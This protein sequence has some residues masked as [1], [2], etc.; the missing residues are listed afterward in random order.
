MAENAKGA[1]FKNTQKQGSQPDLTGSIEITREFWDEVKNHLT[2]EPLK[3]R[4]AAWNK[5]G[6]S[7]AFLSVA[8]NAPFKKEGNRSAVK[9][10]IDDDPPF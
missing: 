1:L 2:A 10:L 3:L 8:L 6:R 9:H 4:L 5:K 7:G